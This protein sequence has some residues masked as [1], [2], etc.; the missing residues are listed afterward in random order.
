MRPFIIAAAAVVLA[1]CQ[2][3]DERQTAQC[4]SYGF[5]AGSEQF[6]QCKMTLDMQERQ[7]RA[8][9]QRQLDADAAA[10]NLAHQQL[11]SRP[12]TGSLYNGRQ[13]TACGWEG[14]QWVCRPSW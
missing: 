11:I 1:A 7:Q 12:L 2:T 10:A 13:A 14:R 5:P 3:S 4:A 8:E 6:A 9:M